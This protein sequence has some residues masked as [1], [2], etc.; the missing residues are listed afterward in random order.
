M[1]LHRRDARSAA[2]STHQLLGYIPLL[3]LSMDNFILTLA[4]RLPRVAYRPNGAWPFRQASATIDNGH[5]WRDVCRN[6]FPSVAA[7]VSKDNDMDYRNL[8]LGLW[9]G[10]KTSTPVTRNTF[11]VP[12]LAVKDVFKVVQVFKPTRESEGEKRKSTVRS[13]ILPISYPNLIKKDFEGDDQR[14]TWAAP[15]C[16]LQNSNSKMWLWKLECLFLTLLLRFYREMVTT[17]A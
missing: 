13:W 3:C 5:L 14:A 10:R 16:F 1:T 15:H 4:I 11:S 12:T 8:V 17:K 7:E 6:S 9:R 2:T